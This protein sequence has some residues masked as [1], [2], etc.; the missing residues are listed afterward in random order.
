MAEMDFRV[1]IPVRLQS[2]RLPEK[3]L[4][5]IQG[6][7]MIQ[8]VYERALKSGATSVVIATDN[9][10]YWWWRIIGAFITD[11]GFNRSNIPR[12]LAYSG[13][14][15]DYRNRPDSNFRHTGNH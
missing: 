3:A 15:D 13:F 8:H 2:K 14:I 6:K 7:P 5:D 4:A 10:V 9:H 12:N 11:D 1:I